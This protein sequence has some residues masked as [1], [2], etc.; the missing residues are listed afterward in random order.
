M[1]ENKNAG[2]N[3]N[4][5]SGAAKNGSK[6]IIA[7]AIAALAVI[8]ALVVVIVVLIGKMNDK[9]QP[10]QN[11]RATVSTANVTIATD[12]NLEE[13]LAKANEPIEDASYVCEM[14]VDWYFE[15]AT[16]P[17]YNANVVNAVENTRTVYFDLALEESMDVLYSSPYIP[18][19]QKVDE[20]TL[21]TDLDAGTYPA[22]VIYHMVDDDGEEVGS[23]TVAVTL[24]IEN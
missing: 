3:S 1:A 21:N 13:L 23:V 17:S 2:G 10:P 7:I 16:Q 15:D 20:V 9:D 6:A 11:T 22:V 5:S 14:N 24:H 4:E 19:G 18:V 12:D 8:A